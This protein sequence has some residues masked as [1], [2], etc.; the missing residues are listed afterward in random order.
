MLI[1]YNVTRFRIQA[2]FV[3]LQNIYRYLQKCS[4]RHDLILQRDKDRSVNFTIWL[5]A[6][7]SALNHK[8]VDSANT[9][10]SLNFQ[11]Q[12]Q[13]LDEENRDVRSLTQPSACGYR[14]IWPYKV[15]AQCMDHDVILTP[16]VNIS[17]TILAW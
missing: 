6:Y 11:P 5:D 3:Y 13:S 2:E 1:T 14:T 8:S 10:P 15:L 4:S 12:S 16:S 7:W 17:L 9:H